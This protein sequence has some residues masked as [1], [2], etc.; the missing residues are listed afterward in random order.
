MWLRYNMNYIEIKE[1]RL[2]MV[3]PFPYFPGS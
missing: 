1:A 2:T 3:Q